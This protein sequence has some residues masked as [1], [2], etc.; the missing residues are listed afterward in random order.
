[1]C[2]F[3]VSIN[4]KFTDIKKMTQMIKHRGPDSTKHIKT[5]TINAGF[6]RLAI[7]DLDKRSDQPMYDEDKR[8]LI[9]LNGEI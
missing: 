5:S 1:M 6:N 4:D 3:C 9:L 2:G 7:V 8:Y